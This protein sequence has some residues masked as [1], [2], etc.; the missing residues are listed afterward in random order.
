VTYRRS[1][2]AFFHLDETKRA[3]ARLAE[4]DRLVIYCGAG[5]TIDRTGL[6]WG[7]LI[8]QLFETNDRTPPTR[9]PTEEELAILRRELTPLQ[10]ASVLAE[11]TREHHATEKEARASL[12]PK[13]QQAL[14][15]GTGWQCGALVSNIIRLCFGLVQLGKQV[16]ILT[17]N[18]DTYLE[19]E[20]DHYRDELRNNSGLK[21]QKQTD[22]AGLIARAAGMTKRYRDIRSSGDAEQIE[23]VYLH[24]RVPPSGSLG[25]RLALSENDYHQVADTVVATLREFFSAPQ[26]AVL[27]LGTSLSDPP[28]L[29]ALSETRGIGLHKRVALVPATSTGFVAYNSDFTRLVQNFKIRTLH[30]GVDLLV[31]DFHFQ[32]AQFCQEILSAVSLPKGSIEYLSPD[33]SARYGNRL[34]HWWDAWAVQYDALGPEHIYEA[35]THSLGRVREIL[36]LDDSADE[37]LKLELWVRHEPHEYR[38]LALWGGSTGILRDRNCLHLEDLDIDTEN[39]SVKAFIE[40]R[41]HY[42][43]QVDLLKNK[44][45]GR[46]HSRWR[47]YF[48]VPI[49]IDLSDGM[50]PVGVV[51]L[52]TMRSKER[53]VIPDGSVREMANIVNQLTAVG[54]E[55]LQIKMI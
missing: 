29:R 42:L 34:S 46:E 27:I 28:L 6:S 32:I 18:Y 37:R 48:C 23:L 43:E 33:S 10:L 51:T 25:G 19:S 49:R 24:G 40:G 20:Y 3:I 44:K 54:Q 17:S 52:A 13:L 41:P 47:T 7:D 22:I 53:S 39:A 14:Y 5:V 30:F 45:P 38:Q 11:R 9:D 55:L 31:P 36:A 50:I 15:K 2:T 4:C 12:I 1:E 35:L 16:S 8:A 26:T 21:G